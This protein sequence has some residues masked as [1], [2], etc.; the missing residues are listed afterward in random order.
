[1][2]D[3]G[4]HGG[5]AMVRR[6]TDMEDGP[7]RVRDLQPLAALDATPEDLQLACEDLAEDP[8]WT[9]EATRR[10]WASGGE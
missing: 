9:A 7:L 8:V 4:L 1:M 3:D 10:R 6:P 2:Q 5:N